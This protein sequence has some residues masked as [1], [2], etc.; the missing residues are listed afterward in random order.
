MQ[1]WQKD[2]MNA[3]DAE[4]RETVMNENVIKSMIFTDILSAND[5]CKFM[6]WTAYH[7]IR[8]DSGYKVEELKG[9]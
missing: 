9:Y 4:R 1:I 6:G 5:F 2:F 8:T 7:I 3:I